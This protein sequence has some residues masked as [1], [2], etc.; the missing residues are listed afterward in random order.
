MPVPATL[1]K[2]ESD[3]QLVWPIYPCHI[4]PTDRCDLYDAVGNCLNEM[5]QGYNQAQANYITEAVNNYAKL[6]NK[7][8]LIMQEAPFVIGWDLGH[9]GKTSIGWVKVYRQTF[10]ALAK[11]ITKEE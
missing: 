4:K 2:P 10:D 3:T 6:K 9:D 5:P 1:L 7:V 8:R 11:A